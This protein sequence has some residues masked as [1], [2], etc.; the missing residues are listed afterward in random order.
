MDKRDII[1]DT[2]A[3]IKLIAITLAAICIIALIGKLR[4]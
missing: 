2:W 4:S 3:T 1:E